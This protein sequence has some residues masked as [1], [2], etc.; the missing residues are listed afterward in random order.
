MSASVPA[1]ASPSL[2]LPRPLATL[3]REWLTIDLRALAALRIGLGVSI[4]CSLYSFVYDF[5]WLATDHGALP[6]S[7][8]LWQ[9]SSAAF[10]LFMISGNSYV[11]AALF[12]FTAL[13]AVLL[14]LGWR[15]RLMAFVC[16]VLVVS[17]NMR[18]LPYT[19]LADWQLAS[20]LF[21][22]M[23]LPLGARFSVDSALV[24]TPVRQVAIHNLACLAILLQEM[25][26]Y[27][28]GA[29]LKTDDVWRTAYTAVNYAMHTMD[30]KIM[31]GELLL[32]HPTLMYALTF[33][34]FHL[35]L[36]AFLLFF[37]PVLTAPVR[38]LG[39]VLLA[40]LHL[41]FLTFMNVGYFPVVSISGL[42]VMLPSFFWNRVSGWA[43]R[44][45]QGA[46]H[47][48]YYDEPCGFCKK[49]AFIFRNISVL[50]DAPVLPAQS[51]PAINAVLQRENSWV[52]KLPDG[53][54]LTKWEAVGYMWRRSPV[55]F[56]FGLLFLLPGF[57]QLGEALYHC[58]ARNRPGLARSTRCLLA[59]SEEM[60]LR[61]RSLGNAFLAVMTGLVMLSNLESTSRFDNITVPEMWRPV[62][63]YTSM[64]QAWG[65]FASRPPSHRSWPRVEGTLEDGT[66]VDLVHYTL[67]PPPYDTL[68]RYASE[69]FPSNRWASFYASMDWATFGESYGFM[70]CRRWNETMPG[71][72]THLT[73]YWY[74]QESPPPG[75]NIEDMPVTWETR[76]DMDC[77][78]N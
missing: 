10:S 72:L 70:Q 57:R 40:T 39:F 3:L 32:A 8:L 41:G 60:R 66:Q 42:L 47:A 67:Q 58:I 4:L 12:W 37:C 55:L 49:L 59:S 71:R 68:P 6:R 25:Y 20:L 17:L 36:Y 26:L 24:K 5:E 34:V 73:V 33:Y 9:N 65:M 23:F 45:F 77:P 44:R 18:Y 64:E 16:W 62:L 78:A 31:A 46:R 54:L 63:Q 52:V 27:V 48:I 61:P 28:A 35:E 21:W 76:L 19:F 43:E 74:I 2:C 51:D 13:C 7:Y 50:Q 1:P 11:V 38:L 15:A 22:G 30:S 53:R 69:V 14:M 56:V 75:G 29:M